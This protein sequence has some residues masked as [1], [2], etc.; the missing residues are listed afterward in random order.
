VIALRNL[1]IYDR[2]YYETMRLKVLERLVRVGARRA[3]RIIFP[4]RASV[5][6]I[7][8]RIPIDEAKVRVVPHGVS[9]E[10]F[11]DQPRMNEH[12]PFLF[13]PATI[14]RHKNISVLIQSLAYVE[15]PKLEVWIAGS[16]TD[17][18]YAR[19]LEQ[20][21][22]RLGLRARVRFLGPVPYEEVIRY[23]RSAEAL[24]FPS[25]LETFGHPLLE[26]MLAETPIVAADIPAFR[27]I[28]GEIALYFPPRDP[29]QLARAVNHVRGDL[30]GTAARV[31]HGRARVREFSWKQSVDRLCS[32]FDEALRA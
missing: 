30:E 5:D 1:N 23:Y 11:R 8:Q 22:E 27:E 24:V 29:V 19:E 15:D 26:A 6:L 28:A 14:E 12:P 31:A 25:L 13:L 20:L 2:S 4:S 21:A 7:R 32:V 18:E 9:I 10:S 3:A 16:P 17:P